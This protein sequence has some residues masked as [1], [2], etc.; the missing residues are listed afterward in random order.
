MH[1]FRSNIIQTVFL[2]VAFVFCHIQLSAQSN[3]S[4]PNSDTMETAQRIP[5]LSN[6][7]LIKKSKSTTTAMLLSAVLPGA[8]QFYNESYWKIPVILGLGGFWGYEWVQMNNELRT[9]KSKYSESLMKFPPAGNY[10]YKDLRDFYRS[11]RDKFA[12]YLGILY[13]L[14]I[15]DAYVDASLFEF[16]VDE[17][18]TNSADSHNHASIKLK[19]SF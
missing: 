7:Q 11:E 14:N 18:L 15:V 13:V 1:R 3:F 16:S 2:H 4:C 10:Q 19:I 6:S 8:G 12:W 9:Y 17:N 5:S